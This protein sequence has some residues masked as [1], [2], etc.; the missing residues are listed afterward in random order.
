MKEELFQEVMPLGKGEM[1]KEEGA[2]GE[3]GHEDNIQ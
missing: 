2:T 3:G 1:Y